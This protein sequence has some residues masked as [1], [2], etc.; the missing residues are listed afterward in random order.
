MRVLLSIPV[1]CLALNAGADCSIDARPGES[2]RVP[3]GSVATRAEMVEA[4]L[5]VEKYLLLGNAY[6]DCGVM[7]RRQHNRL[8]SR[9][10]MVHDD[11][12]R[13][14]NEYR[15]R[16]HEPAGTSDALLAER[17]RAE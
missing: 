14:L 10:E 17:G 16:A 15:V 8:L 4:Q 12:L 9:M 11:Y 13:E 5:A 3:D 6:L 7:N 1:L 2:P